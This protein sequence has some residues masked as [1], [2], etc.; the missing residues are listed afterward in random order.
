MSFLLQRQ[1]A[2]FQRALRPFKGPDTGT[3]SCEV[4][5]AAD[6]WVAGDSYACHYEMTPPKTG[7]S[8]DYEAGNGYGYTVWFDEVPATE[9]VPADTVI[10]NGITISVQRVPE[11]GNLTPGFR[12]EGV[13]RG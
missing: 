4:R 6:A 3:G 7:A 1:N 13:G 8:I 2:A 9:P 5:Y 12:I 11:R 10:V